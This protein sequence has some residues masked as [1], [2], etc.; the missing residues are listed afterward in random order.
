MTAS[1]LAEPYDVRNVRYIVTPKPPQTS[2]DDT[3]VTGQERTRYRGEVPSNQAFGLGFGTVLLTF[4]VIFIAAVYITPHLGFHTLER[5]QNE[6]TQITQPASQADQTSQ[7]VI[8]PRRTHSCVVTNA[9]GN[10]LES[11][12]C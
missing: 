4:I 3:V 12:S 7:V 5:Q 6:P 10:V 9:S 2:D 1:P 8:V 11:L